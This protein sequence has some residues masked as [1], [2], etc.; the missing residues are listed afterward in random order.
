MD[1]DPQRALDL[2]GETAAQVQTV[3]R[4]EPGDLL[5]IDNNR[6]VHGRTRFTPRYDGLDRWL[7]R[8]FITK[9]LRRSESARPGDSRIVE[10]GDYTALAPEVA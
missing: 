10:P 3:L 6:A 1:E 8:S 9:D 5:V 4:L 7:L 2:L